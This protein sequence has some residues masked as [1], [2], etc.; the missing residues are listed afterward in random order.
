MTTY[1]TPNFLFFVFGIAYTLLV[2]VLVILLDGAWYAFTVICLAL[3]VTAVIGKVSILQAN[4]TREA[5][6][7]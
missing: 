5:H 6:K 4:K 1:L 2:T 3:L 7:Q